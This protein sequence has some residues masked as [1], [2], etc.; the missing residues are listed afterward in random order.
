MS[1]LGLR[2]KE[3]RLKKKVSLQKVADAVG[4]SKPHIWELER[5]TSKNPSL[6]L[7]KELAAYFGESVEYLTEEA[8][9]KSDAKMVFNR[10][11]NKMNLSDNDLNALLAAAEI[12]EKNKQDDP[13]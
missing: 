2:L 12:L 7:L 9:E 8:A 5:G 10:K 6:N 13:T 3:L 1:T 4:V 11:I